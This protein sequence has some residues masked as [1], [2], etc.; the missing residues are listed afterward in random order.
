MSVLRKTTLLIQLIHSGIRVSLGHDFVTNKLQ[1]YFF[2]INMQFGY[3][4]LKLGSKFHFFGRDEYSCCDIQR[5][6][7]WE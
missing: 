2:E 1:S 6:A 7:G 5:I 4:V 3:I